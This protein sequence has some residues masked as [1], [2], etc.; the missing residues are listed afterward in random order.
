MRKSYVAT[1]YSGSDPVAE[2]VL[3]GVRSAEFAG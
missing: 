2:K 3:K 1:V